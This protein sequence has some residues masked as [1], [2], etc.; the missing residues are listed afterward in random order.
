MEFDWDRFNF[1]DRLKYKESDLAVA[2]TFRDHDKLNKRMLRH[3][4][5]EGQYRKILNEV[6]D[7]VLAG[8]PDGNQHILSGG[9]RVVDLTR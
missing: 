8:N 4:E 6:L 5:Y 1:G 3:E 2:S 9:E 7:A